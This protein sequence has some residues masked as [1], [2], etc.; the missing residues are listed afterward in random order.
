M[1]ILKNLSYSVLA[2]SLLA[3]SCGKKIDIEPQD[4]ISSENALSS[5]ADVNNVLVGAYTVLAHPALYGTNLVMIP[6]LYASPSYLNWTGTFSTYR[7]ISNQNLIS[8]NEDATRTWTRAYQAI[9]AANTVLESLDVVTD[10]DMKNEIQGK[11]LFIRGIM[12]FELVRLYG[13]PYEAGAANSSL[14]V[15]IALKAV[16]AFED[17]TSD[18]PR[19]TVA[20]V[21]TQ[22]EK[23]L[24]DAVS[25]LSDSPDLYAAK[26]M[27]ARLYLQKSD[28]T[29]ARIQANDIIE[30]G[31]YSLTANLEDPFRVKNSSEGVFEIQQNEQSNAGSSNDG[32]ATF[33]SSYLNNTGGKVG[34]GDLSIL[35]SYVNGYAATDKRRTQMIYE[36]TGAKTGWFTRKWYNY[37]DNIPVVRL[38][39]LYLTRAE[40]NARLGG[41]VGASPASDINELRQRAG[42]AALGTVTVN[43]ILAERDKEL[44]FEGYRIHDLKR[45]KRSI[46]ALP[47]NAPKLVFPI[48][49]REVSVNSKLVQN[50]GYN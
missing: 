22:A 8:T 46:G 37:F 35:N 16:K 11:A 23:D 12:H 45:T 24:T 21:Y 9:N 44:A 36:G 3:S 34:R 41:S 7:D 1:K 29:K 10:P 19:N 18:V 32:L 17:I 4:D 15:P 28:Y 14:G 40:C 47:Y 50:P 27:L 20:E 30:S 39:E 5:A 26:G 6:D 38:T 13:L 49:Y 42:L 25:L 31:E 48:P 33:Y 43:D 2:F